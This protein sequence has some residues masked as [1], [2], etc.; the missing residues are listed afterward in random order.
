[1]LSRS[2][3]QFCSRIWEEKVEKDDD[4]EQ[5]RHIKVV[6]VKEKTKQHSTWL[7]Q[8][9]CNASDADNSAAASSAAA[10]D[11][12]AVNFRRLSEKMKNDIY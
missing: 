4:D 12:A 3:D 1:M 8:S 9:V 5:K 6:V 10:A 11:R 2:G 7:V